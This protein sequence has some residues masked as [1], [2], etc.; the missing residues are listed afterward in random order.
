M[1]KKKITLALIAGLL[2]L[3]CGCQKKEDENTLATVNNEEISTEY[4][5]NSSIN[6]SDME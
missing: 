5:E 3:L 1:K 2:C 4:E 6:S